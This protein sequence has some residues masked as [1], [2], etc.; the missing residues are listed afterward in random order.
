MTEKIQKTSEQE[1]RT[2]AAECLDNLAHVVADSGMPNVAADSKDLIEKLIAFL[3]KDRDDW[4]NK[5]VV[6]DS[7]ASQWQDI[8]AAGIEL[9]KAAQAQQMEELKKIGKD[10]YEAALGTL[11][12][13]VA[14]VSPVQVE[15]LE[16]DIRAYVAE[17]E[18]YK[19]MYLGLCK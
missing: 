4:K 16:Q 5:A 8:H 7:V 14:E 2:W 18:E 19:A 17:L 3:T 10:D 6:Y 13:A 15:R 9:A 1:L 11:L 12:A